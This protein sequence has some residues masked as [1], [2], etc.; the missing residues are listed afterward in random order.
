METDDA[1]RYIAGV[2]VDSERIG[3]F[4]TTEMTKRLENWFSFG[5]ANCDSIFMGTE[6]V[7]I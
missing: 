6:R 4:R 5:G 7:R 1:T 2:R 3:Q